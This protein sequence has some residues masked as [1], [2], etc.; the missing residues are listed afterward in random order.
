M[1]TVNFNKVGLGLIFAGIAAIVGLQ[2]SLGQ[3]GASKVGLTFFAIGFLIM[4]FGIVIG[5]L[6][7]MG[8][9]YWAVGSFFVYLGFVLVAIPIFIFVI[10][11]KVID[12]AYQWTALIVGIA[13]I[14]LGFGTEMYDL[15]M[16]FLNLF[17]KLSSMVEFGWRQFINRARKSYFFI[18][19]VLLL[20][21]LV[22][23]FFTQSEDFLIDLSGGVL[24]PLTS[25][26]L[27]LG[28]IILLFLIEARELVYVF[29]RGA[30]QFLL[31]GLRT[32]VVWARYLPRILAKSLSVLWS[33]VKGLF[34]NTWVLGFVAA[35]ILFSMGLY[36]MDERL[37]AATI[38]D[39]LLSFG[40][41]SIKKPHLVDRVVNNIGDRMVRRTIG[42]KRY[43]KEHPTVPCR[44]CGH[45][46]THQEMLG[47]YCKWCNAPIEKCV[48]CY[49]ML[50]KDDSVISCPHCQNSGHLEHLEKW[51][52]M[53]GK[54]PYCRQPWTVSSS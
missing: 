46:L 9:E 37:I 25:K 8:A 27:I 5:R 1:S 34:L 7:K 10:S 11:P 36:L 35:P 6:R 42:V 29:F 2:S 26:L 14:V 23:M 45:P 3:D 12:I 52:Q 16:M 4:V 54:C 51:T 48:V 33:I 53:T 20:L 40:L 17:R 39:L 13:F 43:I 47:S 30:W 24:N 44:S 15:N 32:I 49:S 31:I 19:I 28:L 41:F 50:G 18:P 22:S 21:Y 38:F